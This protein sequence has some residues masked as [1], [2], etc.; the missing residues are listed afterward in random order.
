MLVKSNSIENKSS[1]TIFVIMLLSL[2]LSQ[3]LLMFLFEKIPVNEGLGWDG[4]IY[5]KM[6]ADFKQKLFGGEITIYH[7][8]RCFPSF[9]VHYSLKIIDY[10][11]KLLSGTNLKPTIPVIIASF[12]LLNIF[13][14]LGSNIF[15]FKIG[16]RLSFNHL[17]KIFCLISFNL[18]FPLGKLLNYCPVLTDYFALFVT[19]LLFYTYLH[20]QNVLLL[21]FFLIGYFTF[22]TLSIVSFF[23]FAFPYNTKENTQKIIIPTTYNKPIYIVFIGVIIILLAMKTYT[24]FLKYTT[25]YNYVLPFN[26]SPIDVFLFPLSVITLIAYVVIIA[27]ISYPLN[28]I[29]NSLKQIKV[30]NVAIILVLFGA[31]TKLIQLHFVKEGFTPDTFVEN[32]FTQSIKQPF[33]SFL[34]H[35]FY[36]GI[37]F[38]IPF[39]YYRYWSDLLERLGIGVILVILAHLA[40]MIGSET[41]QFITVLPFLVIASAI[42]LQKHNK[43]TPK[44]I[45]IIAIISF[46]TSTI[47]LPI[48]QFNLVQDKNLIAIEMPYL[49]AIHQGPWMPSEFYYVLLLFTIISCGTLIYLLKPFKKAQLS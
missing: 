11:W 2:V 26:Q 37:A 29:Q 30:V 8:K 13:T 38:I 23:L 48:N 45:S 18:I 5:Y 31:L 10:A 21:A 43:L 16:N 40:L 41:R 7:I 25:E 27:T 22:P 35:Y 49:Y 15:L 12:S 46:I 14:I 24:I 1:L 32:I 19:I 6:A 33:V 39:F 3:A 36:F 44:I 47:W 28:I 4:V 9:I 20:K 17:Q 34:C 42:I